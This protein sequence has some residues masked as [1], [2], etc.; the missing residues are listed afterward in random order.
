VC[1]KPVNFLEN[2]MIGIVMG[3]VLVMGFVNGIGALSK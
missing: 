3:C 2:P 1:Y